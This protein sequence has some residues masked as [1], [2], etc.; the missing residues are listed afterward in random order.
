VSKTQCRV[1]WAHGV[2]EFHRPAKSV[3]FVNEHENEND[4]RRD[5]ITNSFTKTKTK[6]K[7][8]NNKKTKTKTKTKDKSKRKSHCL[9]MIITLVNEETHPD[10]A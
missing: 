1:F 9:L 7:L 8:N 6:V 5:K 10:T 2:V 3:I 4:V